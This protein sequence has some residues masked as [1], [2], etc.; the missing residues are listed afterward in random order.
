MASSAGSVSIDLDAKIA[1]FESDMGRAARLMER[2]LAKSAKTSQRALADMERQAKQLGVAIGTAVVAGV[3]AA[4]YAIKRSID[5]MDDMSKSAQRVGLATEEFS[6]LSYAAELADVSMETL[7]SSLG[8]L[9]K[10]QAAALKGTSEQARVFKALGIEVTDASGKMRKSSDVLEE[11]A[12]RFAAMKGSPEAMAAGFSLFGRSFQDLIPLFKD[13]SQGIRDA[14]IELEAFGGVISTQAGQAAEEF[15]DNLTRLETAA[16]SLARAVAADLLPDLVALSERFVGTAKDGESLHRV[17]SDI[18]DTIRVAGAAVKFVYGYFDAFGD[19]VGGAAMSMVGFAEAAKGVANLD[20]DQIKRGI[21]VA[22]EGADLSYYGEEEASRRNPGAYSDEPARNA[23]Q[24]TGGRRGRPAINIRPRDDQAAVDAYTRKLQDALRGNEG[25]GKKGSGSGAVSNAVR[26]AD[27]LEQAYERLKASQAEQI[28]LFGKTG[29]AAKVAYDIANGELAKLLPAKQQELLAQAQQL[30]SMRD[31]QDMQK[32]ADDAVRKE[33]EA[34][35]SHS[36]AVKDQIGDMQFELSLMKLS[37]VEREKAIARRY[38]NV[39]AM[40]AEGEEM[41][42]IIEQMDRAAKANGVWSEGQRALS[43]SIFD[44]VK[45][46]E[47]AE[48]IA[49]RFF[50]S[51]ADSITRSIAED[52]AGKITGWLKGLSA[53]QGAQADVAIGANSFGAGASTGGSWWATA[54]SWIGYLSSGGRKD[55]GPVGQMAFYE[56]PA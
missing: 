39:D 54:L 9:T 40:S 5:A 47:D 43:D 3:T 52:W 53:L 38:A 6:K 23:G 19:V 21:K 18:A 49:K 28:E 1:K 8:K 20:W 48:N 31:I 45:N 56:V 13:G 27:Q 7:A 24:S 17:A 12:D 26:E 32:A 37:N 11:F 42:R 36:K 44:L 51:I 34:Y 35:E 41:G 50:N 14:G 2:D 30:D 25:A 33:S 16:K 4:T 15:N 46:F 10:S 22:Q 55:G 29:E